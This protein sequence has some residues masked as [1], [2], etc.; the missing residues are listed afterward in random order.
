MLAKL[1]P[2]QVSWLTTL[3]ILPTLFL[4]CQGR[5]TSGPPGAS[6]PA[7]PQGTAVSPQGTPASAQ[8]SPANPQGAGAPK[9][10]G[11]PELPP[12]LGERGSPLF[13]GSFADLSRTG[14]T[15]LSQPNTAQSGVE[16]G[17][18]WISVAER[19]QAAWAAPDRTFTD[20]IAETE[21]MP[22]GDTSERGYGLAFRIRTERDRSSSYYLLWVNPAEPQYAF[23]R[24]DRGQFVEL[25][26]WQRSTALRG[27]TQPNKLTVR[28]KGARID[29]YIN[30]QPIASVSDDT[31]RE[32]QAALYLSAWSIPGVR[33]DFLSFRVYEAR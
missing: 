1:N 33:A 22:H 16:A 8:P 32:G 4:A 24:V 26:H 3:L 31:H 9:A 2:R 5:E 15:F 11:A 17:A 19:W 27:G 28:A 13:T 12:P 30:D 10:I 7:S 14:L 20:F 21:V 23:H 18:Y 25:V 6:T 29:L